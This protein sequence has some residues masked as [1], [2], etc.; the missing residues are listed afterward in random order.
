MKTKLERDPQQTAQC[1]Y[2][3]PRRNRQHSASIAFPVNVAEAT[4]VKQ[5]EL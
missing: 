4:L 1:V 3:I 5:A 2:S